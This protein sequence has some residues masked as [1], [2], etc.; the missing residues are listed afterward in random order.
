MSTLTVKEL[1]APTGYDLTLASG[2]TLDLSGGSVT[3]P[4]GHILQVVRSTVR[5]T[6]DDTTSSTPSEIHSD[7][8]VAITPSSTSSKILLMLQGN[9]RMQPDSSFGL[10]I[11]RSIDGGSYSK[12]TTG[13]GGEAW[14][15]RDTTWILQLSGMV[16]HYDE[17]STTNECIYTPYY[18]ANSGDARMND[19]GLGSFLLAMEIAG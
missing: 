16:T 9:W 17:P 13:N 2:E 14:R 18:W 3:M 6:Q 15:N 7:Y 12:V 10:G 19:N 4:A 8:R 5:T 11:Y 1:A